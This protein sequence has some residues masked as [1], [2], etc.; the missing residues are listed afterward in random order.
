MRRIM[1]QFGVTGF[2]LSPD[3]TDVRGDSWEMAAVMS[4]MGRSGVYSGTLLAYDRGQ[5]RFGPV[6][7]VSAKRKLLKGEL[8]T[9]EEI[10][11]IDVFPDVS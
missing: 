1:R 5:A 7:G 8:F 4:I 3:Y 6:L 2:S 11:A 9:H 10:P